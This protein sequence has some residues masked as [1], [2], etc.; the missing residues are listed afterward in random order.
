[1]R[2][3][4][5]TGVYQALT[6]Y[7]Y[8]GCGVN[9]LQWSSY[10]EGHNEFPLACS[11]HALRVYST[12]LQ[13]FSPLEPN[14]AEKVYCTL[15]ISIFAWGVTNQTLTSLSPFLPCTASY[16]YQP[17]IRWEMLFNLAQRR[18]EFNL[19]SPQVVPVLFTRP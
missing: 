11:D 2:F 19:Y 7:P 4:I 6:S 15:T 5:T 3:L 9:L 10:Q 17:V 13:V 18:Q 1:M 14:D 16:G 8:F 12:L